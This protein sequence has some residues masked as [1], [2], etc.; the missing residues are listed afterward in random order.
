MDQI[1]QFIKEYNE[2]EQKY[3]RAIYTDQQ[4]D[5]IKQL[6]EEM[7][8]FFSY[9]H[10]LPAP[11]FVDILREE[12][13]EEGP[14]EIEKLNPRY[15]Y[16]IKK[17]T[18][19][20]YGELYKVYLGNEK[21]LDDY[22]ILY[23]IASIENTLKI[24]SFYITDSE[25]GFEYIKGKEIKGLGKPLEIMKIRKPTADYNIKEYESE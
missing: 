15:L 21:G 10:H 2:V 24:I 18:H 11:P 12:W 16:Q 8:Q 13:F 9:G 22:Y 3:Y 5:E 23:Y 4:G 25:G 1:V 6:R 20:D 19:S 7:M 17:Y 14:E